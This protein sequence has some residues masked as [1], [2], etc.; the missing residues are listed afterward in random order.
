MRRSYLTL[1]CRGGVLAPVLFVV[2]VIAGFAACAA[3]RHWNIDVL[4]FMPIQAPESVDAK[5]DAEKQLAVHAS[6]DVSQNEIKLRAMIADVTKQR[7]LLEEREKPLAVHEAQIEQQ[8]QALEALKTQI[9]QAE[10]AVKKEIADFKKELVEFKG[11]EARNAKEMGK[12]WALMEPAG[13][14][15]V[16]KGMDLEYVTKIL[17]TMT[18]KQRSPIL[19][20]LSAPPN[21]KLSA[22]L[23][24][25]FKQIHQPTAQEEPPTEAQ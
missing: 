6:G 13:V 23:Q 5:Q 19:Q 12:T 17:A 21:E 15:S 9:N 22:E 10:V 14:A 4:K 25:K 24:L 7:T 11:D 20:E 18:A 8:R 1:R 16:I 3:P 2:G